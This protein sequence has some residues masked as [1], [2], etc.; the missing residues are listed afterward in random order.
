MF[1]SYEFAMFVMSLSCFS[2]P[3]NCSA[4]PTVDEESEHDSPRSPSMKLDDG[5][6]WEGDGSHGLPFGETSMGMDLPW[7]YYDVP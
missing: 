5:G 6:S 1:S 4:V 7:L 3:G 2:Q